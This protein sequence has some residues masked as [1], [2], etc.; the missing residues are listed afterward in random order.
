MTTGDTPDDA[1]ERT[2]TTRATSSGA[3]NK[4]PGG[5]DEGGHDYRDLV[6][7]LE[8]GAIVGLGLVALMAVFR[9][10]FAASRAISVWISPDFEPVF[11]AAFNLVVLLLA[12]TGIIVFARRRR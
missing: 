6:S 1:A 10:Y 5:D 8:W 4:T 9:F 3:E 2:E 11:Q 12:A 7:Y